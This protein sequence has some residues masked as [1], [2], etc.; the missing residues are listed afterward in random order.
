MN[1]YQKVGNDLKAFFSTHPIFKILLPLDMIII[2]VCVGAMF[3]N[4]FL[5]IG[6]LLLAI[7]Y[8]GF[9]LGLILAL[10]NQNSQLLYVGLFIYS[11]SEAFQVIRY[12]T[13][14]TYRFLDFYSLITAALFGYLGYLVY[15]QSSKV[16]QKV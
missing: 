8:Y 3:L 14:S 1:T 15:K 5:S 12:A 4:N 2:Y 7:A 16:I 13:F 9:F 11:A 6:G 10:S